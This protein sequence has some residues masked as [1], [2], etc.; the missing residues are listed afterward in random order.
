MH[1]IIVSRDRARALLK[2]REFQAEYLRNEYKSLPPSGA[3]VPKWLMSVDPK[4]F[5]IRYN[6]ATFFDSKPTAP[7]GYWPEYHA[8]RTTMWENVVSFD[9]YVARYGY[10]QPETDTEWGAD[11]KQTDTKS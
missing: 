8:T 5:E 6:E 4:E 11:K 7:Q 2:R 1:Y 3:D 9:P 10:D